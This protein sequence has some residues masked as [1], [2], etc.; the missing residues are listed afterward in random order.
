MP[1]IDIK[2]L[3]QQRADFLRGHPR[4]GDFGVRFNRDFMEQHGLPLLCEI[5]NYDSGGWVQC[6][7]QTLLGYAGSEADRKRLQRGL[8]KL[9]DA[10]TLE[11]SGRSSYRLKSEQVAKV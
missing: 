5:D 10:G 11:R 4:P 3:I 2:E 6:T 7:C 8:K 9:I 1:D